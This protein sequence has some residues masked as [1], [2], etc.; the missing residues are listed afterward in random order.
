MKTNKLR[1]KILPIVGISFICILAAC[2]ALDKWTH[3]T[4]KQSRTVII[5][6]NVPTNTPYDVYTDFFPTN[7]DKYFGDNNTASDLIE[8]IKTESMVGNIPEGTPEDFSFIR[9]I[10]VFVVRKDWAQAQIGYKNNIPAD[11]GKHLVFDIVDSEL[12][13]FVK[14]DSIAFHLQITTQRTNT[15]EVPINGDAIFMVDARI[16][17]I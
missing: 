5:P 15:V 13:N 3:F 14:E 9:S 16:L 4:V 11:V 7:A 1:G 17:G 2:K 8:S 10:K 6:A 12:K